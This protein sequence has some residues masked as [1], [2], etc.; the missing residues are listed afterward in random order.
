MSEEEWERFKESAF[1]PMLLDYMG[2]ATAWAAKDA[3]LALGLSFLEVNIAYEIGVITAIRPSEED[4][5]RWPLLRYAWKIRGKYLPRAQVV[6]VFA[7]RGPL[8]SEEWRAMGEELISDISAAG[9][10]GLSLREFRALRR[11]EG[12]KTVGRTR[13]G[14]R[15]FRLRDI[16]ALRCQR[17]NTGPSRYAI[18]D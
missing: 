6:R 17:E 4:Y 2:Q 5:Q 9:H 12:W 14:F 18:S 1:P 3:Q 13:L 10:L 11:A 8:E 16:D 15:G 7:P